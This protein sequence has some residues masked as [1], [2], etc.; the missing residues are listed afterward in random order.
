[1]WKSHQKRLSWPNWIAAY[2]LEVS[3]PTFP[4]QSQQKLQGFG[5]WHSEREVLSPLSAVL[6]QTAPSAA[7]VQQP[8]APV[9]ARHRR[10]ASHS[11]CW[12]CAA[13]EPSPG[14]ELGWPHWDKASQQFLSSAHQH[15]SLSQLENLVLWLSLFTRNQLPR[16]TS[17]FKCGDVPPLE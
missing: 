14:R 7:E 15:Y 5:I 9:G 6:L 13:V 10:A 8:G 17:P 11:T 3:P 2:F 4:P 16:V 12:H 1:M